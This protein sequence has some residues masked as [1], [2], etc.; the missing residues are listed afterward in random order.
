MHLG[1][2]GHQIDDDNGRSGRAGPDGS[3]VLLEGRAGMPRGID[4]DAGAMCWA[5][6]QRGAVVRAPEA[7]GPLQVA[8]E[9]KVPRDLV[10]APE[11]IYVTRDATR[12]ISIVPAGSEQLECLASLPPE[13][14]G[15]PAQIGLSD[16]L[17]YVLTVV[18]GDPGG[19]IVR[20]RRRPVD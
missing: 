14:R 13:A 1:P 11:G 2:A 3:D 8:A 16:E 12:E 6:Y 20:A 7:G 19:S 18:P 9:V 15:H 5:E 10:V 4:L 17:V